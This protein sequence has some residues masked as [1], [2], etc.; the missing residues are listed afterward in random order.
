MGAHSNAAGRNFKHATIDQGYTDI[1][2]F[3]I[4]KT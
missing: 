4:G 1:T 3:L 2:A